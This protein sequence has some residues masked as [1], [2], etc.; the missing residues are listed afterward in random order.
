MYQK[1]EGQFVDKGSTE[2]K[3]IVRFEKQ[4]FVVQLKLKMAPVAQY[5]F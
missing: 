5:A 4:R 1:S 2:E 3:S